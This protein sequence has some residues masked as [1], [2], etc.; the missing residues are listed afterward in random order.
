MADFGN[1]IDGME[2]LNYCN[3][4]YQRICIEAYLQGYDL[5]EIVD[6]KETASLGEENTEV[7]GK[8]QIKAGKTMFVLRT[9]VQKELLEYVRQATSSKTVWDTFVTLFLKTND[10]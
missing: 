8:W 9:T 10:A 4:D 6:S 3:Y 5:W 7:L 1:F 2:K